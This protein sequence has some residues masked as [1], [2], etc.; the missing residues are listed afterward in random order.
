MNDKSRRRHEPAAEAAGDV[1]N[2]AGFEIS[3]W[4]AAEGSQWA[5]GK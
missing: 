1:D 2:K 4:A 3:R 5:S